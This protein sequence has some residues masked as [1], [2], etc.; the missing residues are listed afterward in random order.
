L[1]DKFNSDFKRLI[2]TNSVIFVQL[3]SSLQLCVGSVCV[4]ALEFVQAMDKSVYFSPRLNG[5]NPQSTDTLQ[6]NT[7]DTETCRYEPRNYRYKLPSISS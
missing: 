4:Q 6:L 1:V 7:K 3:L 5:L 2:T